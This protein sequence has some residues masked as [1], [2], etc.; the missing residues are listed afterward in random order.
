MEAILA[1]W[2]GDRLQFGSSR[3]RDAKFSSHKQLRLLKNVED[4]IRSSR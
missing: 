4:W 3:E 2:R 1:P